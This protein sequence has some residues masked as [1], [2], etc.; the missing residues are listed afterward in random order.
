MKR[1]Y[2]V[3]ASAALITWSLA[4]AQGAPKP[5][6]ESPST[7]AQMI[8]QHIGAQSAGVADTAFHLNEMAINLQ[9]SDS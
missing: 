5:K 9:D 8:F 1:F 4:Q 2:S 6:N 3:A 7:E